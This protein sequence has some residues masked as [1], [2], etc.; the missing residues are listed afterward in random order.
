VKPK[1][2][3]GEGLTAA[4]TVSN[5]RLGW[6]L[7]NT[8]ECSG[9]TWLGA[10]PSVLDLETAWGNPVTTK[11]NFDALKNVGFN[12]VR[13]PVSWAKCANDEYIIRADWMARVKDVVDYAI[14]NDMYVILNTHHDEDIF[15][16]MNKDMAKSRV[17]FRKIWE[18]I[19]D[20]FNDYGDKLIFEALNEPRTPGSPNEWSGGTPEE[21]ANLNEHYQIFVETVRAS[22]GNNANRRVLIINT[23]AASG[24]ASPV[25]DLV[26][27]DDVVSDKIIVSIHTYSP[28]NFALNKDSPVNTWNKNNSDDTSPITQPIDRVYNAFVTKG[29][30][31]ILGEFGALNKNN[32]AARTEWSEYY[33]K[34][35][36]SKGMPCFWWDN[37][38]ITGN[39]ENFGLLNRTTNEFVFP[40]IVTALLKGIE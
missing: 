13:L 6:N 4:E 31:V 33:V 1:P 40:Q 20:A 7:A 26:V 10:N 18:Q 23:Y 22:G 35:A 34:Y 14:D 24:D 11:A 16:F 17:A 8:L 29:I 28:Y 30:P 36:K 15:R 25:N 5:I 12:A 21:R 39:G 2:D 9:L 37:G 27:P 32:I 3:P 38:A 19:A